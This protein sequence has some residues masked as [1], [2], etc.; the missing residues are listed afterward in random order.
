[1]LAGVAGFVYAVSFVVLR[2]DLLSALFLLLGGLLS[3][4]VLVALFG[5]LRGAEPGFALWGLVLGLA[6][7]LGAV[8]HGGYDLAMPSTHPPR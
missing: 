6:G 1:V 8:I 3:S 5:R 4:S 7:A 2:N